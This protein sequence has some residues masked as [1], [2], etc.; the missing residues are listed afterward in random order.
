M[1][2]E[3]SLQLCV[4]QAFCSYYN[5]NDNLPSFFSARTELTSETVNEECNFWY[6][7]GHASMQ[8][9]LVFTST[10]IVNKNFVL[11]GALLISPIMCKRTWA[12]Q[13]SATVVNRRSVQTNVSGGSSRRLAN[14][15][16]SRERHAGRLPPPPSARWHD[17]PHATFVHLLFLFSTSP[18]GTHRCHS[19]LLWGFYWLTRTA[20]STVGQF[21]SRWQVD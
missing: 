2:A 18:V 9:I 8:S 1:F 7:R 20:A 16:G 15:G 17:P 4:K 6:F 13:G 14:S 19:A 10:N 21:V 12:H 11:H 5:S 3:Q